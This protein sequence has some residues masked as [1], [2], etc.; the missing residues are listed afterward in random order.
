MIRHRSRS[1]L[2]WLAVCVFTAATARADDQVFHQLLV[3]AQ[4]QAA[5]G[6]YWE[7]AADNAMQTFLA[8]T[9]HLPEATPADLAAFDDLLRSVPLGD[10]SAAATTKTTD[11]QSTAPASAPPP[12]P[13]SHGA[14]DARTTVA[15]NTIVA[16]RAN[17]PDPGGAETGQ[18]NQ[19]I[20]LL[21]KADHLIAIGHAYGTLDDSAVGTFERVLRLLP[22]ASPAEI[23]AFQAFPAHL[24]AQAQTAQSAGR[25]NEADDYRQIASAVAG[26]AADLDALPVSPPDTAGPSSG[27][28]RPADD[29]PGPALA[30]VKPVPSTPTPRAAAERASPKPVTTQPA[31]TQPAAIQAARRTALP[32]LAAAAVPAPA[33]ARQAMAQ[34]ADSRCRMLIQRMQIGEDLADADRAFLRHGCP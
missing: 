20:P 22:S 29:T 1:A 5:A 24:E 8:M 2:L 28:A 23:K 3:R 12:N 7:P 30:A 17:A 32:E 33:P 21:K 10:G 31:T 6:H 16:P 4:A 11:S 9:D 25:A 19:I 26:Y 18:P 13:A 15:A 34:Q 27:G 14:A